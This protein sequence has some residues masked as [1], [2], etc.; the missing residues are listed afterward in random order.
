MARIFIFRVSLDQKLSQLP[1]DLNRIVIQVE[2]AGD[3]DRL[4]EV[5]VEIELWLHTIP[6]FVVCDE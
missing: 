5:V 6:P 2:R 3:L 4:S 1:V